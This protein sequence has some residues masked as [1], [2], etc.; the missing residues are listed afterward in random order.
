MNH[1]KG[2]AIDADAP[3][4]VSAPP[5]VVRLS[6]NADNRLAIQL[7]A[8]PLNPPPCK[9]KNATT[10]QATKNSTELRPFAGRRGIR[11]GNS[12]SAARMKVRL[13]RQRSGS[14]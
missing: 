7:T 11:S 1:A 6:A 14:G 5:A 4:P 12:R 8:K 9:R 13:T 10:G 2:P 3:A